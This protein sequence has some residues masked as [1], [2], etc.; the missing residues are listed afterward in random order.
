MSGMWGF[1][2]GA[3][4]VASGRG[5]EIQREA[6]RLVAQGYRLGWGPRAIKARRP[7]LSFREIGT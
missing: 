5:R 6:R 1:G 2:L 7:R 4:L 3:L